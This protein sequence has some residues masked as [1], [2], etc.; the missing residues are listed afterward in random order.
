MNSQTHILPRISPGSTPKP[1]F[2]DGL[3]R[4]ALFQRFSEIH[5][6]QIVLIDNGDK[7]YFGKTTARCPLIVMLYVEDPRFYSDVAFGGSIGAGEAYMNGYWYSSDLTALVRIM[8]SNLDVLDKM[9]GG[10]ATLTTPLQKLL[11]RF[12]RNTQA[13]SRRNIAAHYDLG[14][15]FFRLMLDETMMYSAAI[16]AE[17]SMSLHDAQRHRL[18]IICRKLDLQVTDHLLEIGTG[19]GGLALHA[20]QHYG[21]RVTTTT[22][23]AEQYQLASE[24]VAAA[25]LADRVTVIMQDYRELTGKYDKL[26]SIEM[27]EAIGH[28]HYRTYFQ[29]CAALLKPHGLMLIQAITIADQRH[30]QAK[31]SVDFIQ[32]YIFPGGCLPSVTTLLDSITNHSDMRLFHLEDI[33]PHYAT[34][35]RKWRDN[36]KVNL[37]HIRNLGYSDTFL[38]MWDYYLC[39]CEGG[40]LE[41]TIGTVQML[42][43][44]PDN[45][46]PVPLR[47]S[48]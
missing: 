32:R 17:P 5:D 12:N 9:E 14:N 2:L 23:S 46:V 22:I 8:V 15:A 38:R 28:E 11:H 1:R 10:W 33:G 25:G 24:R 29:K 40:F 39:Y 13:G 26:V 47:L 30:A 18:D 7:T 21:C 20:A 34:T 19:W 37:G 45:R 43:M 3:A 6:G 16:F 27:I 36:V 44:K 31:R 41:R 42:L 35:L 48:N 4:R